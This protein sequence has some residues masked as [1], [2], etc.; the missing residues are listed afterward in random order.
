MVVVACC[1]ESF[2]DVAWSAVTRSSSERARVASCVPCHCVPGSVALPA[3]P[4]PPSGDAWRSG[5]AVVLLLKVGYGVWCFPLVSAAG[6]VTVES[7]RACPGGVVLALVVWL[8]SAASRPP[9]GDARSSGV[10][11]CLAVHGMAPPGAPRPPS[12]D[13]RSCGCEVLWLLQVESDAWCCEGVLDVRSSLS[14]HAVAAGES[15]LDCHGFW[16]HIPSGI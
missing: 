6:V 3:S 14:L 13:A 16:R 15:P 7:C 8:L 12:G 1:L 10:F 5:C 2:G 11:T 9:S 4:C